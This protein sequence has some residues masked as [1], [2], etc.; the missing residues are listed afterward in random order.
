MDALVTDTHTRGALAGLRELGRAGIRAGALAARGTLSGLRS[1]YAAW[2]ALGPDGVEDPAGYTAAVARLAAAYGPLVVYPGQEET[3]DALL[4]AGPALPAAAILPYALASLALVRDKRRLGELAAAGGLSVP[5]TLAEL[6]AAELLRSAP[7]TPFV[8][9]AAGAR[10]KL[11]TPVVIESPHELAA[12]LGA[13]PEDEPLL[14]QE[15]AAGPLVGLALVLGRDGT[16]VARF[17]Q[18]TT[19]TWPVR[20][21]GTTIAVGVAPDAD[22]VERSRA[23]LAASGFWGLAHLQFLHTGRG[24]ALI[25]VNPRFYGSLPLASASGVNLPAI[26]HAVATDAPVRPLEPYRVGV[27]YRWLEG[28][29]LAA[30]RRAP[31]SLPNRA[32][33]PSAGAV[34]AAD[35][36]VASALATLEIGTDRARRY[37][38]RAR[39]RAG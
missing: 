13:L 11:P 16:V 18:E 35:D 26:W 33:R 8:V 14:V 20:A 37:V 39:A 28:E 27:T 17:Q 21:G 5:A 7:A 23:M 29:L 3:L 4:R 9:K 30:L 31:R 2:R 32:P 6:T 22:L 12:A 10:G 1:R 15:H 25:D 38:A 19:H 24:P 34:W 36:P